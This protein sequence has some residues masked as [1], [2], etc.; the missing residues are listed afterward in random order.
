[1]IQSAGGDKEKAAQMLGISM[2]TLYRKL[3]S[4]SSEDEAVVERVQQQA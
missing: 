2:A 1:V 3:A 4:P